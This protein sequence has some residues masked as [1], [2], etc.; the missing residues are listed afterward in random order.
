MVLNVIQDQLSNLYLIFV[1]FVRSRHATVRVFYCTSAF[2]PSRL[3]MHGA[4]GAVGVIVMTS[5]RL[6]FRSLFNSNSQAEPRGGGR[7]E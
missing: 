5:L 6:W 7:L 1:T 2:Q 3:Q 4:V